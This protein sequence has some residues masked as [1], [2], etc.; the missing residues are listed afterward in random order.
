MGLYEE[1]LGGQEQSGIPTVD[2]GV[3]NMLCNGIVHKLSCIAHAIHLH[4]L[5]PSYVLRNYDWVVSAHHC[6]CL[7]E[8]VQIAIVSDLGKA[9]CTS[10]HK[11]K[12]AT[13]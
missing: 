9:L 12:L 3:F 7:Q 6:S 13:L 10:L 11:Y 2:P 8:H 5:C 1:A 4:L